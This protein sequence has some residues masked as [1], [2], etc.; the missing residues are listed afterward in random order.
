MEELDSQHPRNPNHTGTPVIDAHRAARC[1]CG[2]G[3]QMPGV[4]RQCGSPRRLC[5]TAA[6]PSDGAW[7]R[8]GP[9]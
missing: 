3:R 4:P 6:E 2:A 8:P 1:A 5:H 9:R 7:G